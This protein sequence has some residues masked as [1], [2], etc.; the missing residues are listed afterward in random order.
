VLQSALK[1]IYAAR[2]FLNAKVARMEVGA[3]L[4]CELYQY[5]PRFYAQRR[6]E[7][8]GSDPV[9][10]IFGNGRA[11]AKEFLREVGYVA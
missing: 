9:R 10:L 3:L 6:V 11:V 5:Q 2:Y 8:N 1:A 4:L 7:Q